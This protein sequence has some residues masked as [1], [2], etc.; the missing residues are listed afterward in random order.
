MHMRGTR[1]RDVRHSL[2]TDK[3]DTFFDDLVTQL[4]RTC[5]SSVGNE[6]E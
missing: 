2:M 3:T 4:V 1:G 6:L 5:R